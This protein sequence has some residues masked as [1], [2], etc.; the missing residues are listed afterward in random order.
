M[1]HISR[2]ERSFILLLIILGLSY[3]SLSYYK[4]IEP[5]ATFEAIDVEDVREPVN[6]N[7]AG[8]EEI[9]SLPGL[10]PALTQGVLDYRRETGGFKSKEE[11]MNVKGVGYKKFNDLRDLIII[12]E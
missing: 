12:D 11:L 2:S 5:N 8:P 6:I 4:K 10:G 3:V 7:M 9:E 1:L